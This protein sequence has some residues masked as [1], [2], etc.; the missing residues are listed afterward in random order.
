MTKTSTQHIG[1]G[2][3]L[4]QYKLVNYGVDSACINVFQ[5]ASARLTYMISSVLSNIER[6]FK[7]R[8]N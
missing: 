5:F 7:C 1:A 3:L 4:V 6:K 2:E 8:S